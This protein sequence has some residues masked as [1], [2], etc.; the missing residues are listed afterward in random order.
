M[1]IKGI[2]KLKG[3]EG[4]IVERRLKVI[5]FFDK[6]G[7]EITK[8]AFNISRSTIYLWKKRLRDSDYYVRAL[9]PFSRAPKKKR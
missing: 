5:E 9:I 3:K 4:E 8:E 2:D 1:E 7:A 6:Y